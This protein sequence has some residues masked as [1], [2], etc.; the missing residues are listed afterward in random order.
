MSNLKTLSISN[1]NL[2]PEKLKT[3]NILAFQKRKFVNKN[4]AILD[5]I[6]MNLSKKVGDSNNTLERKYDLIEIIRNHGHKICK[7]IN[8]DYLEYKLDKIFSEDEES[9]IYLSCLFSIVKKNSKKR[10]KKN[11]IRKQKIRINLCGFCIFKEEKKTSDILLELLCSRETFGTIYL[12]LVENFLFQ[13]GFKTINVKALDQA[14]GFYLSKGFKFLSKSQHALPYNYVLGQDEEDEPL[15]NKLFK[16]RHPILGQ[17]EKIKGK[18]FIYIIINNY[19]S[20]WIYIKD[21]YIDF[22]Q[23]KIPTNVRS[24]L[25]TNSFIKNTQVKN[26]IVT[27]LENIRLQKGYILMKKQIKKNNIQS[28]IQNSILSSI[29]SNSDSNPSSTTKSSLKSNSIKENS[30]RRQNSSNSQRKLTRK[31]A[32]RRV[33]KVNDSK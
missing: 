20:K 27:K 26:M 7:I 25:L 3:C 22:R 21:S 30:Q 2:L 18:R 19:K 23:D 12:K 8:K 5:E 32:L 17:I 13:K 11:N 33:Y 16:I 15:P 31:S 9:T 28:N 4:H 24:Y 10:R 14:V 6:I 29:T 1:V